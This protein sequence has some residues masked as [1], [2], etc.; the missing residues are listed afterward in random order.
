[1][2]HRVII[3][4]SSPLLHVPWL[5]TMVC[6]YLRGMLN[7]QQDNANKKWTS[8]I[9]LKTL[10]MVL[11]N[12]FCSNPMC[13]LLN[14]S[15]FVKI[16]SFWGLKVVRKRMQRRERLRHL[17][18]LCPWW[19]NQIYTNLAAGFFGLYS[20]AALLTGQTVLGHL[21]GSDYTCSYG[22]D[23]LEWNQKPMTGLSLKKLTTSSTSLWM[24]SWTP[25]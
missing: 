7:S 25:Y 11:H 6:W 8:N 18:H 4:S 22:T 19:N 1:M 14:A 2:F 13:L 9:T 23:I 17:F 12:V 16:L 3:S 5:L 24:H 10:L 20:E 15:P 21:A